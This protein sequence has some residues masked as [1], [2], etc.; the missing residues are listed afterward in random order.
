MSLEDIPKWVW[1]WWVVPITFLLT[2]LGCFVGIFAWKAYFSNDIEADFYGNA[3]K[4]HTTMYE[5]VKSLQEILKLETDNKAANLLARKNSCLV[6]KQTN[7]TFCNTKEIEE[8]LLLLDKEKK[9]LEKVGS[10]LQKLKIQLDV[11]ADK[12]CHSSK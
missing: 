3:I 11:D 1:K 8:Q 5:T 7:N 6:A 9:E 2:M 4:I 12:T 10:Q